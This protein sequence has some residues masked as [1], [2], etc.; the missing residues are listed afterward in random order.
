MKVKTHV[1]VMQDGFPVL[2]APGDE[3]PEGVE[4]TNPAALEDAPEAPAEEK[5]PASR[6]AAA[7]S[8]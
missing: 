5:K 8:K 3:V 4:V 2:L 6:K 1:Y 7:D